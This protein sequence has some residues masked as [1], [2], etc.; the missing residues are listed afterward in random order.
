MSLVEDGV[1][2]LSLTPMRCVY[3]IYILNSNITKI[4]L[5]LRGNEVEGAPGHLFDFGI[6]MSGLLIIVVSLC[7]CVLLQ[8]V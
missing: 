1:L 8:Y 7:Y 3:Y 5:Y 6:L 4:L 2:S